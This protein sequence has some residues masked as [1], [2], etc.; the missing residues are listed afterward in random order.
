MPTPPIWRRY[1]KKDERLIVRTLLKDLMPLLALFLLL[2]GVMATRHAVSFLAQGDADLA[3]VNT[4]ID[5]FFQADFPA[6]TVCF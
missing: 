6:A 2:A 5:G 1:F 3:N 4:I